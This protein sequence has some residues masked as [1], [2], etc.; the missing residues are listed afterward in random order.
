MVGRYPGTPYRVGGRTPGAA[1]PFAMRNDPGSQSGRVP[2]NNPGSYGARSEPVTAEPLAWGH[3][4]FDKPRGAPPRLWGDPKRPPRTAGE[5]AAYGSGP[6]PFATPLGGPLVPLG[7]LRPPRVP[8]LPLMWFLDLWDLGEAVHEWL[9][10]GEAS[11]T[12]GAAWTKCPTPTCAGGEDWQKVNTTSSCTPLPSCP[13]GQGST[14]SLTYP[15]GSP[16]PANMRQVWF[17]TLT[18]GVG[19][20]LSGRY[21]VRQQYTRPATGDGEQPIFDP[22][23]L[24][25]LMAPV[26][27]WVWPMRPPGYT[28]RPVQPPMRVRPPNP[29]LVEQRMVSNGFT[30]QPRRGQP[31]VRAWADQGLGVEVVLVIGGTIRTRRDGEE[32]AGPKKKTRAS[33]PVLAA[34]RAVMGGVTETLDWIDALYQALPDDCKRGSSVESKVAAL[35]SCGSRID[36][37]QAAWNIALMQATDAAIG[38]AR[39]GASQAPIDAGIF[40]PNWAGGPFGGQSILGRV[41]R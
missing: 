17:M 15:I 31:W 26:P 36:P 8:G 2:G 3:P 9:H 28:Q 37:V 7:K 25:V 21:T 5:E 39:Q 29:W 11:W 22:G 23:N 12:M 19:G 4:H 10:E 18:S 24:V 33:G 20:E 1:S 14:P 27:D 30:Q 16:I 13:V 40:A 32:P 38:K 35:V 34:I 6:I 41:T